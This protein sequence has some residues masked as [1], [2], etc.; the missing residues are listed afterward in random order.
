MC[1]RLLSGI[2]K[3][4][5]EAVVYTGI[6]RAST[7]IVNRRGAEMTYTVQWASG[8][9]QG[10]PG[11]TSFT[12]ADLTTDT[13]HS[14]LT[15]T[16]RDLVAY[17]QIQQNNFARMLENFASD[18]VAPSNPTIGQLWY[19]WQDG[20]LYVAVD[21]TKVTTAQGAPGPGWAIASL[22]GLSPSV[23]AS[24][25]GGAPL[26]TSGMP[27]GYPTVTGSIVFDGTHTVTGLP[28]PSTATD[29]ASKAYVD[30]TASS[31]NVHPAATV[32][33]TTSLTVVYAN[34]TTDTNGGLGIGAT[35]TNNGTQAALVIDGH[36]CAV[37]DRILVKNQSNPIQNG[38]YV[39]SNIGS[40]TSNWVLTR[41]SDYDDSVS[42]SP[43]LV[44][45]GDYVF[46]TGGTT[47]AGS[48]WVQ[49]GLGTGTNNTI[50]I[51]TNNINFGQFSAAAIY[52]PGTGISI[53]GNSI[54]NSGVTS[55]VAGTNI[56][57]SGATGAVTI[58][59]TGTVPNATNAVL[60]AT[61]TAVSTSASSSA[62]AYPIP[63]VNG[64]TLL[65]NGSLTYQASTGTLTATTFS[66]ALTGNAQTATSAASATNI[67]GGGTGYLP[68]QTAANTTAMLTPGVNGQV[69]TLSAGVPVWQ[70]PSAG[71][72][73]VT[74][75]LA[76]TGITVSGPTGAV[77]VNNS[78]ILSVTGTTGQVNVS[79][80]GGAVTLSLP[81]SISTSSTPVFAGA[82][83]AGAALSAPTT[84]G[85]LAVTGSSGGYAGIQF[86]STTNNR[87]LMMGT[88]NGIFGV[89]D[90]TSSAW[91][92]YWTNGTLTVGTVPAAN[93]GAGTASINI[94]GNAATATSASNSTTQATGTS[95]STIATTQFVNNQIA[96]TGTSSPSYWSYFSAASQ[97]TSGNIAFS[98]A[99]YNTPVGIYSYNSGT[100]TVK[101]AGVYF[102]TGSVTVGVDHASAVTGA[103]SLMLYHNGVP[104]GA[105]LNG[106]S[107]G[108]ENAWQQPAA[109][110]TSYEVTLT[111]S[112]VLYCDAIDTVNLYL[113]IPSGY[114][115]TVEVIDGTFCGHQIA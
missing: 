40:S 111:V 61:A 57:V 70:N 113:Y 17:G 92:M 25:L 43:P 49:N 16:G 80:S 19:N 8:G 29:A 98:T 75:I 74:S 51:G 72:G 96:A 105:A 68:Y 83:V 54:S 100:V 66:G 53:V 7:T 2:H 88:S 94:S 10:I 65:T 62:T 20:N 37:G 42:Q 106:N 3:Y 87:T 21:P 115:A 85:S 12:I 90:V 18:G 64:G 27:T 59:L 55:L 110:N 31:L 26:L 67:A 46:V 69:L 76:G 84:Y 39:V 5:H 1:P 6:L 15:L 109:A 38:V 79:N 86:P 32:A 103:C 23:F 108:I 102:V 93:I 47:Q 99:V 112:G 50:L 35:L 33:T 81:Q 101:N 41:A 11:K 34:G 13:T 22:N 36:T 9:T 24:I 97:S 77:T 95:N 52:T 4:L 45:A 73:V 58:S 78:G 14:S 28:L 89:Y 91:E 114:Y 104:A 48:S 107:V 30:N 56:S 63:F 44:V 82:T 60:A 71:S